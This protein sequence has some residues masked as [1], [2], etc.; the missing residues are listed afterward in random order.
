MAKSHGVYSVRPW[1]VYESPDP[2]RAKHERPGIDAMILETPFER[3][4]YEAYLEA[5]QGKPVTTSIVNAL[6]NDAR[7][8]LGLLVYAHSRSEND[9]GYLAA[10]R[11][12]ELI[13][14]G[15]VETPV[16]IVRFGPSQDFY[17]VGTFREERWTGSITYRFAAPRCNGPAS[18]RF[19]DGH[20]REYRVNFDAERYP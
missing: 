17:D 10:F 9:R 18:V 16:D 19:S 5:I 1:V 14:N 7:G 15:T 3:V 8:K 4:R 2:L 6:A 12:A 20:G 13:A 11:P